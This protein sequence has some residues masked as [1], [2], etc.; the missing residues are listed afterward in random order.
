MEVDENRF[1]REATVHICGELNLEKSMARFLQ[2]LREFMPADRLVLQ[3]FDVEAG[4]V[5][6]VVHATPNQGQRG[7]ARVQVSARARK[8]IEEMYRRGTPQPYYVNDPSSH[9]AA[10]ELLAFHKQNASA[11]LE[12]PFSTSDGHPAA[13]ILLAESGTYDDSSL[14][15]MSL[16]ASPFRVA[17]ANALQYAEIVKLKERLA[18]DNRY[19]YE[20]YTRMYL[21]LRKAV[22]FIGILF[23]F[24]LM[25]GNH[26]VFGGDFAMRSISRYY[27]TDMRNVFVAALCA[28]ALFM[29]FYSGYGRRE[30][31]AGVF[32]GFLTIGVAF[33]PTTLEGPANIIGIAHYMCAISLFLLLAWISI[34]HFP[35]K[36][37]GQ[38][39]RTTDS[40]QVACGLVMTASV[41]SVVLYHSVIRVEGVETPFVFVAETVALVAFGLSWLTEG[42]D[43]ESAM[44]EFGRFSHI[45]R[46]NP[47]HS[48]P[49]QG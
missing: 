40:V 3:R 44:G 6:V 13:V 8:H 24:A 2:Y 5:S 37:P 12:L 46:K 4:V 28:I 25:L 47:A 29:F 22:G 18:D 9:P 14:H 39:W 38:V 31:W 15:L 1:F 42:F 32:A 33:F 16:L 21:S 23:P 20:Q 11:F 17:L 48:T 30:R 49:R 35:R 34:F 45:R 41:V 19:L 7:D 27:H 43:M 10:R 26:F 36:L